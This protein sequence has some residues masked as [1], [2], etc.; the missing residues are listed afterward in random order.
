MSTLPYQVDELIATLSTS[1]IGNEAI[2]LAML[3]AQLQ[4]ALQA[5]PQ[6]APYPTS[7]VQSSY[8][9]GAPVNTPIPGAAWVHNMEAA[10]TRR[11]RSSSSASAMSA[12]SRRR[13]TNDEDEDMMEDVEEEAEVDSSLYATSSPIQ[14]AAAP[15]SPTQA[16]SPS[17]YAYA[18]TD[19]FL[20]AQLRAAEQRNRQP[21]FF[22]QIA[23]AQQHVS[24]FYT[25]ARQ[26]QQEASSPV[27]NQSTKPSMRLTVDTNT[28]LFS[29]VR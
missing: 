9:G 8:A 16:Y 6:G 2:E 21:S 27:Q 15:S 12:R 4:Q 14:Y 10:Q 18:L 1:H 19:P 17:T 11:R 23:T 7:P 26:S 29:A 28:R 22:A 3:Q 25:A 13:Q 5:Y 24:P 20:A